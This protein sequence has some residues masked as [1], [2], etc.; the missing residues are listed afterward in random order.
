M[1]PWPSSRR[2]PASSNSPLVFRRAPE[3]TIQV[4]VFK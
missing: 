1:R 2:D 3:H 4:K